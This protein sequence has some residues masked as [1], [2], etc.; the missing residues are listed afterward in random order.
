M[1]PAK[2]KKA[3]KHIKNNSNKNNKTSYDD[4]VTK[5][6]S[7]VDILTLNG[8]IEPGEVDDYSSGKVKKK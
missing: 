5:F 1:K 2:R 3:E 7:L 4:V 8:I 6:D